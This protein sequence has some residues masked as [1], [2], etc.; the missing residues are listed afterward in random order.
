ME[1]TLFTKANCPA[2]DEAK[3]L[4]KKHNIRVKTVL[5]TNLYATLKEL[6]VSEDS[7]ISSFPVFFDGTQVYSSD[8]FFA[9]YGEFLL[10]PNPDRFVVFPIQYRDMWEA[11]EKA[12]ASFWTVNEINFAQDEAD[13]YEKLNDHERTFIKNI[14]AFFAASDGI[15]NENLARNFSDEIQIP[16]ARAFYSYQQFNETI[17]SH[18]YSL[19]I[20]RYVTSV[21][22]KNKLLRG[23]HTIPSIRKKADWAM[24]WTRRDN[25][26]EF[27]KRLI[28]F[29]CVEGI[30]FSGS[31]CAIFWL[32]KRGL[33]HGLSFSNELISRDEGTH[34]DFAVLLFRHLMHKPTQG[35]VATIV[36]AAVEHEKEFIIASIPCR[37]VGMNEQLMSEY[38]EYVADRLMRQLGYE[39]IYGTQNPFDFMEHISLSGKT[40]FFERRVG[41]YAKAGVVQ[42]LETTEN[43]FG[44]DADF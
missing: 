2:C 6:R 12:L 35:E 26:P 15:V 13:F 29:A 43:V 44:T 9:R 1:F 40:N 39:A 14:L 34:Q 4:L 8:T 28:A 5:K 11:Y 33:M 19:M 31:F 22:E 24:Q 37:L 30:M 20:D 7:D 25:C 23:I 21:D 3:A 18:T 17:H 41:E 10:N 16:E 32:K 38:I 27:A 42:G 36:S